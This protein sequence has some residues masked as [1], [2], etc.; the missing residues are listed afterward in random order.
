MK[1]IALLTFLFAFIVGCSN[2]SNQVY[3]NIDTNY[4]EDNQKQEYIDENPIQ[5]GIY[6]NDYTLVKNYVTTKENFKDLIFSVY[7]TNEENLG[8]RNQKYNWNKFYSQYTNIE[9]YKIGF[10]FSFY[11]GEEKIEKNILGPDI[12]CFEPYFY[13]YLYDDI[14]QQD[15]VFYSHLE[16]NDVDDDTIFSSI[17]IYLVDVYKITSPIEFT[18][19]TYDDYDDFDS[20]GK[21]RGKSKY[22]INIYLS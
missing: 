11:V 3:E 17:K 21:Y 4:I 14:N 9:N 5:I 19:F 10:S 12:Y 1:K 20:Y 6:E 13:V 7:Y 16:E 22:T 18:A 15:G 2:G 8:N